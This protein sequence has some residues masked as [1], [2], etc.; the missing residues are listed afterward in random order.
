MFLEMCVC[1]RKCDRGDQDLLLSK[2]TSLV[3]PH[4]AFCPETLSTTLRTCKWSFVFVYPHMNLQVLLL[5]EG[6]ITV[7]KSTLER[8]GPV[9]AVQVGV[10]SDLA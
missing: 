5:T 7:M 3:V 4:V 6:F 2:M 9:V 8:L 10:Q 1:Q